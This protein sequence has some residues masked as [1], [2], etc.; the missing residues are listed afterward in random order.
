MK[1]QGT[2]EFV[3]PTNL[4]FVYVA[5]GD[6]A[7]AFHLLDLGAAERDP[8]LPY[9]QVEPE[10]DSLRIDSRFLEIAARTHLP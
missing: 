8:A 5:L 3:A 2:R 6:H 7:E 1:S 9:L 4:A 10:L